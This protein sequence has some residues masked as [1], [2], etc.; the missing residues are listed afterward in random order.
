ML[1]QILQNIRS[2]DK[3]KIAKSGGV[4]VIISLGIQA[5]ILAG[6]AIPVWGQFAGIVAGVLAHAILPAKVQEVVDEDL[7]KVIDIATTIP[8]TY[9][10]AEDFPN[11]PPKVNTPNNIVKK[12]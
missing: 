8:Q 12:V 9:S 4:A 7:G 6:V 11:A 5:A 1:S 2:T 3:A 10:E